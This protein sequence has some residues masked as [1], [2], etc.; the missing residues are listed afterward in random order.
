MTLLS[1]VSS[2][3]IS[4]P[5]YSLQ[6]VQ[7]YGVSIRWQ[8]YDFSTSSSAPLADTQTGLSTGA[9]AGIG[10]GVTFGFLVCVILAPV[11]FFY[12]FRYRRAKPTDEQEPL[13]HDGEENNQGNNG[14][15]NAGEKPTNSSPSP[16]DQIG[17]DTWLYEIVSLCFATICFAAMVCILRVYE[18][19]PSPNLPYGVTP[20]TIISILATGSKSSLLFV[21][22]EYIGQLKWL[23]F[24]TVKPLFFL[25]EYDSASRGPWGSLLVLLRR[26]Q[27][28]FM[29]IG[30]L[31]MVLALTFD[32]FVQQIIKYPL[33]E[34]TRP[35]HSAA[36]KQPYHL[37][38]IGGQGFVDAM[39]VALWSDDFTINPACRQGTVPGLCIVRWSGAASVKMLPQKL[40]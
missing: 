28:L 39:N 11:F 8:P 5:T 36:I 27:S 12:F 23:A 35:S 17:L 4:V 9:K 40:R 31:I 19:Q 14:E 2:G 18:N 34:V 7:A 1:S 22:G 6:T 20:N 24:Q 37:P 13:Q 26:K 30:A 32:P 38:F 10:A 15:E 33:R 25:Q 29:R 21:V 3:A 16:W